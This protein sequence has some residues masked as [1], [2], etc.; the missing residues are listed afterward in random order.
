M[1]Y[2]LSIL[3]IVCLASA[4]DARCD[5]VTMNSGRDVECVIL[6]ENADSIVI[7]QGY[8]TVTI[9]RDAVAVISKSPVITEDNAPTT[10]PLSNQRLPAWSVIVA[11]LASQPWATGLQQIPAT[12]IDN[13]ALRSVP[14]QSYRCGKDY[15]VNI[16]GDPDAPSG[17]E[18]GIYRTLLHNP[19]AK[20]NCIRF[21]ASVLG[22]PVDA[23][24]VK[25]LDQHQDLIVRNGQTTEISP[26]TEPD[27]YGGWWVSVYN[28]ALLDKARATPEELKQITVASP[29]RPV[30]AQAPAFPSPQTAMPVSVANA[31]T[32][33]PSSPSWTD[34]TPNDLSSSSSTGSGGDVYVRGYYRSNGTYVQSYTRAA[35]GFGSGRGH[36]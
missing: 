1:K 25:V 8:G 36:R 27:S 30:V 21:A 2:Y 9:P 23:A 3:W 4:S 20:A 11:Q 22:D 26:E 32:A 13:G 33:D 19:E 6:Q 17:I 31:P 34:W 10:K 14:Y 35:P 5:T 24:I 28:T 7:R 16:Y 29:P 15:E 18:I 12:V